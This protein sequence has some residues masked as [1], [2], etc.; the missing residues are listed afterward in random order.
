MITGSDRLTPTKRAELRGMISTKP[1]LNRFLR[2]TPGGLLRLDAA[3]IAAA[4]RL[5]G[6]YLLRTSDP[7]LSTEDIAGL[8]QRLE[9]ERGWRDMKQVLDLR[10]VYHRLEGRIRAHVVPCWLALLLARIRMC[11]LVWSQRNRIHYG[12]AGGVDHRDRVAVPVRDVYSAAARVGEQVVRVCTD[13]QLA[14]TPHI[15]S[16]HVDYRDR[17]A[18][19]VGHVGGVTI[20][21]ERH[22]EGM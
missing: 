21:A 20:C 4:A 3:K 8:Q 2:V 15:L 10:P 19:L 9:V 12:V 6:K 13:P 18:G 11:P 7:H 22:P 14:C 5:D 16:P 1:G 17:V